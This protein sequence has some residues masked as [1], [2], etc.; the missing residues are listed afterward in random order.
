MSFGYSMR[1]CDSRR[2]QYY[3]YR[4]YYRTRLVSILNDNGLKQIVNEFTKITQS[5]KTL[6]DYI[7]TNMGNITA[8][9]NVDNKTA[10]HESID[11][12]IEVGNECHVRENEESCVL[13]YNRNRF[14]SKLG[15]MI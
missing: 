5:S 13:R 14:R 4:D 1:N 6:I 12:L 7:I 15:S 3:W 8:R 10:D 9:T 2:F 11:I